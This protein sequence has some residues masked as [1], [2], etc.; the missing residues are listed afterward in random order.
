MA[1]INFKINGQ[2]TTMNVDPD[3]PLLWAL[4]DELGLTGTKYS[5]GEGLCGC[6]TV[7]L[8]GEA[9]RSCVTTV[10]EAEGREILTIEGLGQNGYHPLQQAWIEE[11][12][13][14]C[15]YCQP[16]QIMI[17]AA[18]LEKNPQPDDLDID[19]EMRQALCRCG[20]YQRIRKAIHRAAEMEV[21]HE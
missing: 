20:T 13:P 9:V 4:R 10:K 8:N 6:C 2:P 14:Q 3:M 11:E 17:A 15:G 21:N 18:M 1:Q 16:G 19:R 7:H 5:C 12:V